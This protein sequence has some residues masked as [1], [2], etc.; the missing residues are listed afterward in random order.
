MADTVDH[1]SFASRDFPRC[2]LALRR[3]AARLEARGAVHTE[4]LSAK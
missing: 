4:A 1:H 2:V 3:G